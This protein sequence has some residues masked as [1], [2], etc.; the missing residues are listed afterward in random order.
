MSE[1]KPRKKEWQSHEKIKKYPSATADRKSPEKKRK[2]TAKNATEKPPKPPEKY[3]SKITENQSD[4]AKM[5][6]DEKIGKVKK[7]KSL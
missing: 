3:R 7:I 2:N 6:K 4:W 5:G 1:K